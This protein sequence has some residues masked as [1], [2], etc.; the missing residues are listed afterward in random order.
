MQQSIELERLKQ[1]DDTLVLA[2]MVHAYQT[3]QIP[4]YFMYGAGS[5]QHNQLLL[6]NPKQEQD[7]RIPGS[8]GGD[9][10][11]LSEVLLC[12]TP[13]PRPPL[14]GGSTKDSATTTRT[15]W[16]QQVFAGGGHSA[17][18][19]VTG[20]LY[21]FGWNDRGQCGP[22]APETTGHDD[23]EWMT[24][25]TPLPQLRVETC[26]LG[27]DHTLMIEKGTGTLWGMGDNRR[28]QVT[29]S[30]HHPDHVETP[31]VVLEEPV[32]HV[33]CGLHHSAVI[34]SRGEVI[35]FGCGRYG[36]ALSSSSSDM[37]GS[38]NANH[39]CVWN[40]RWKP[41]DCSLQKVACGRRHTVV[42]DEQGRVYSW[43]DNKYG[44]LG[45]RTTTTT[46]GDSHPP[47][48]STND[49]TTPQLIQGP[50]ETDGLTVC[51][52]YCGWSHTVILARST[53]ATGTNK[54]AV[55]GWGRND[56]GQL[57]QGKP[58][59]DAPAT[60][61]HEPVRMFENVAV[62][63]VVC[64]SECTMVVD[65]MEDIWGCGWNEHGNLAHSPQ[66]CHFLWEPVRVV[67][68]G[69]RRVANP[70]SNPDTARVGL[71]AGGAHFLTLRVVPP[72]EPSHE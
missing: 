50:W 21:L 38:F 25:Y 43:G 3:K 19:T 17:L 66:D 42:L 2:D 4:L 20:N 37:N 63:Q 60:S 47:P 28:G 39:H 67:A 69:A 40:K 15:D 34:T 12:G 1:W 11:Q 35:V 27:F 22:H 64:G 49:N 33:A 55:Y 8:R 70:P 29:G 36:Q 51:D 30:L 18:L 56:K 6:N 58:S 14:Q 65:A 71:A 46:V 72:T 32:V 10:A 62:T 24:L 16:P 59:T 45:R 44:Q 52:I 23:N 5:N 57:G 61:C 54:T 31:M 9:V 7:G 48:P 26:A 13:P 53:T 68:D 41:P